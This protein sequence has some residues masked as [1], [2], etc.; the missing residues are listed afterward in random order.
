LLICVKELHHELVV[1]PARIPVTDFADHAIVGVKRHPQ[2]LNLPRPYSI[3][4]SNDPSA[5]QG[6]SGGPLL[7]LNIATALNPH[8]VFADLDDGR[9]FTA[10]G[11]GEKP[12]SCLRVNAASRVSISL[13]PHPH[14]QLM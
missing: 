12:F 10:N 3:P 8:A 1:V 5:S 11:H 6:S 14:G 4:K 7:F 9:N 2:P 13:M